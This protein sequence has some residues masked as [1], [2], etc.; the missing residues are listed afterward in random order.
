VLDVVFQEDDSRV[1][2]GNA[3]HNFAILRRLA[4]SPLKQDRSVKVGVKAKRLRAAL[5]GDYLLH[6]LTLD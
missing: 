6:V 1:R 2:I 4:L 5:D 3:A